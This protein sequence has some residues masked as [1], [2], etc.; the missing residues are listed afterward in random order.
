MEMLPIDI[1]T[2]RLPAVAGTAITSTGPETFTPVP[3]MYYSVGLHPWYLEHYAWREPDFRARLAGIIAHPQVLA[4]GEA[5]LDK[6]VTVPLVEQMDA[7]RYQALLAE[8]AGKPLIVHL[9]R[10]VTELLA[11]RR[12]LAP[13]VPWIVHGF[14]GKAQLAAQL[15]H[16][17]LYL[18]FGERYHPEA[19]RFVPA[20]RLFL[21]T[22]ESPV[23]V[24]ELLARAATFRGVGEETLR[25][26]LAENVGQCF[27]PH[28][29]L[30]FS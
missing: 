23:P 1:H 27:G 20:D 3:G 15:V 18:S 17:G 11:L 29:G 9:V 2:H 22:D 26:V 24:D 10:A 5:G 25:T 19:L 30:F 4:V 8:E 16:H 28:K 21:E 12:E 13:R 7:F 6:T 14:R